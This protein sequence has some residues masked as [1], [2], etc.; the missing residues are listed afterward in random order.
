MFAAK[1]FDGNGQNAVT[2]HTF[3]IAKQKNKIPARKFKGYDMLLSSTCSS[4][5]QHS[6]PPMLTTSR[7]RGR[8]C[9]YATPRDR[10]S[11]DLRSVNC[12]SFSKQLLSVW[13]AGASPLPVDALSI[14]LGQKLSML[15]LTVRVLCVFWNI[16]QLARNNALFHILTFGKQTTYE[17]QY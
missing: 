17:R 12:E 15:P 9:L 7:R 11:F 1:C 5:T 10:Y 3:S 6:C 16:A 2:R 4:R 13:A 8:G 14:Q